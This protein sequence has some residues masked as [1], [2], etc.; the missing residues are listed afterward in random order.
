MTQR[1]CAFFIIIIAVTCS[2]A[3][4]AVESA[5]ALYNRANSLYAEGMYDKSIESYQMAAEAGV[6]D[7]RLEY[8]LANAYLKNTPPDLGRAILHYERARLLDPRDPDLLYNLEFAKS[9]IKEKP[10]VYERTYIQER[11]DELLSRISM[12]EIAA[13]WVILFNLSIFILIARVSVKKDRTRR[14]LRGL[15]ILLS[16]LLVLNM[17]LL[18]AKANRMGRD[19]AIIIE[20]TLPAHSGPGESNPELFE[21]SAGILVYRKGRREMWSQVAVPGGLSGWV[22][23]EGIELVVP[24]IWKN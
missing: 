8:N 22:P 7:A 11:W 17:P 6:R 21:L 1:F 23:H 4:A 10:P 20:A 3:Y 18:V 16:A 19:H 2:D 5:A 9:L 24:E 15:L 12:N 14:M 13:G